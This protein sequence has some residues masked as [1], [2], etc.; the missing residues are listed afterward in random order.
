MNYSF[1][2]IESV[3]YRSEI[4]DGVEVIYPLSSTK[5]TEKTVDFQTA[6]SKEFQFRKGDGSFYAI[7]DVNGNTIY[8]D[9]TFSINYDER[10][11]VNMDFKGQVDPSIRPDSINSQGWERNASK[12][13][14]T[15][16]KDHPEW[17]DEEN[18][19]RINKGLAPI[20]ND[21]FI[22][23]FPSIKNISF[24]FWCIIM[25]AKTVRLLHSRKVF[26]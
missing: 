25:V 6:L 24:R 8:C 11:L 7:K 17:F 26:M 5:G 15:L 19:A 23:F 10:L 2:G 21:T 14:K 12:Y 22:S 1:D 20:V 13:F 18:T 9:E 16:L 3:T 4:I